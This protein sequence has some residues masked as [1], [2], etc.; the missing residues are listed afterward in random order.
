MTE[1]SEFSS[2]E[3]LDIGLRI[4]G[5]TMCDLLS[6]S[7]ES[8]D[9]AGRIDPVDEV[10]ESGESKS[11]SNSGGKGNAER[12]TI[13]SE[14]CMELGEV[15]RLLFELDFACFEASRFVGEVRAGEILGA[16]GGVYEEDAALPGRMER[17][18]MGEDFEGEIW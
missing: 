9:K 7:G 13:D 17:V 3:K 5:L 16:G 15:G 11:R 10:G 6:I 2:S 14:V 12:E 4:S 18:R 8:L 1:R